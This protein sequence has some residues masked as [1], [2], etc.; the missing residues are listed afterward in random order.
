MEIK[1]IPADRVRGKQE[2]LGE[3]GLFKAHK[4]C[5]SA[6]KCS[7]HVLHIFHFTLGSLPNDRQA[8]QGH[9]N[10]FSHVTCCATPSAGNK[11]YMHN[12]LFALQFQH[13]LGMRNSL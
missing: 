5:V 11:R 1:T 4:H 6:A 9:R 7:R 2:Y 10:S 8:R 12:V 3:S 13:Q